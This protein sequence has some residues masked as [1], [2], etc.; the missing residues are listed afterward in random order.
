MSAF[1][2]PALG[3]TLYRAVPRP[4]AQVAS[5]RA[6]ERILVLIKGPNPTFSYYL[7]SRLGQ[8]GM[9]PAIVHSIED[10]LP[11]ATDPDG[12]FVIVC[13]YLD[14]RHA[15]WLERHRHRLSGIAYFVD[16]DIASLIAGREAGLGYRAYVAWFA[17]LQLGRLNRLLDAVWV[18]TPR[19]AEALAPHAGRIEIVPPRP[20]LADHLPTERPADRRQLKIAFHAS[21]I[22]HREH[23]FLLPIIGRVLGDHGDVL[24]EVAARGR[25]RR[26]WQNAGIDPRQLRLLPLSPWPD[27]LHSSRSE[28][29]DILLVP[30]LESRLN[31]A[32]ADT[33]RIDACRM[34][35][36]AVF[37]DGEAY[38]R[39]RHRDEIL[40]DDRPQSWIAALD[41]LIADP[42]RR[43]AATAA[44]RIMVEAMAN[45]SSRL[46]LPKAEGSIR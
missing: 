35:A 15:I 43:R 38:G 2:R 17:C 12:L 30:L 13:R 27:Y 32:R 31:A 7:E 20:L 1:L 44:T 37:S 4:R 42:A 33:K 34:G 45:I 40:L 9:P 26:L 28:G 10:G 25:S 46:P 3:E 16:D 21:G 36:A 18:S 22:H 41:E 19:L 8:A 6:V 29:A 23:E 5:R 39:C 14:R 11:Q 24:F